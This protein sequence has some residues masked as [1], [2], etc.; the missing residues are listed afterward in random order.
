M[1]AF[2]LG[3]IVLCLA[4]V[5]G[6]ALA[7]TTLFSDDAPLRLVI[8]A[9]FPQLVRSAASDTQPRDATLEVSEGGAPAQSLPIKL[10]PRGHF[11]RTGDGC[12]FPPLLLTFDKASA[13]GTLF[14]GQ[15]ALKLVTYCRPDPDYEQRAML[16]YLAYRLYNL[17]T[18]LSFR[19]RAAEVTYR[20]GEGDAGVTRFGFLIEDVSAVADRNGL[21]RLKAQTH[22]VSV[23]RLDASAAARAALFEYL[24]GNLDWE[25]IASAKGEPC[26]HNIRLL[27]APD[28]AP[29][30]AQGVTPVPYDFDWTGFVDPPYAGP[31]PGIPIERVT[32]RYFRGYCAHGAALS[33]A[34]AEFQAHRTEMKALIDGQPGLTPP[35]RTK[36]QRFLDGFFT[37]LDDPR[38]VQSE[39]VRH[40]R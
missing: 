19:V 6:P 31:P 4:A 39:L 10:S 2:V 23:D 32:D 26:C 34:M 14:K 30:T 7:K 18:P 21:G 16:E 33:A 1:R 17:V 28:A 25:F 22:E 38:R 29:A 11:R 36:T 40:C 13:R 5:Q 8:T 37:V 3:V 12:R 15:H 20:T 9:P 35:F 27:A 24:L